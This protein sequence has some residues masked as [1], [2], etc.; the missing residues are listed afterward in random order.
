MSAL[1]VLGKSANLSRYQRNVFKLRADK[2]AT[3]KSQ[4]NH[5]ARC[6]DISAIPSQVVISNK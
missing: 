6:R 5:T 4:N 2:Y 3:M 1:R